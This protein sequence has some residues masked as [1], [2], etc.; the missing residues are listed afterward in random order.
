M[1]KLLLTIA[2]T[3]QGDNRPW[4]Q[5]GDTLVEVALSL[6]LLALVLLTAFNTSIDATQVGQL[7]SQRIVAANIA[8][9]QAEALARYRDADLA[10]AGQP[11]FNA[12]AFSGSDFYM[13]RCGSQTWQPTPGAATY[14]YTGSY[15]GGSSSTSSLYTV[16]VTRSVANAD[17]PVDEYLFTITVQWTGNNPANPTDKYVL[18]T[19][20]ADVGQLN[21]IDCSVSG[22]AGGACEQ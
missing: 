16:D 4:V 19:K 20:L 2:K 10:S 3:P 8:Q 15:L 5:G 7:A 18:Y 1:L 9:G 14:D 21:P 11:F 12:P 13:C 6:G 22:S 17:I